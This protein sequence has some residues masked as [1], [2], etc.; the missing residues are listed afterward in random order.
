MNSAVGTVQRHGGGDSWWGGL[1]G[2]H[3]RGVEQGQLEAAVL[4]VALLIEVVLFLLLR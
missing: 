3:P 4:A 1:R 2:A